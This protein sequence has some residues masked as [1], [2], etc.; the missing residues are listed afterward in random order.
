MEHDIYLKFL[1][2]LIKEN[3]LDEKTKISKWYH[4]EEISSKEI[5]KKALKV[6]IAIV[7][8]ELE[9]KKILLIE[10]LPQN[11]L[12]SHTILVG[13]KTELREFQIQGRNETFLADIRIYNRLRE[14]MQLIKPKISNPRKLFELTYKFK[15][16]ELKI[17]KDLKEYL[18]KVKGLDFNRVHVTLSKTN[19]LFLPTIKQSH[20]QL[21]R[22]MHIP[23]IPLLD[24]AAFIKDSTMNIED[25]L[26]I[27]KH[28]NPLFTYEKEVLWDYDK[29]SGKKLQK[30]ITT[31]FI[32]NINRKELSQ[33]INNCRKVNFRKEEIISEL[34]NLKTIELSSIDAKVPMPIW[35]SHKDQKYI[36]I[37]RKII[38]SF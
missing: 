36:E 6:K 34:K 21:A 25:S 12:I 24:N 19:T 4:G 37:K 32:V 10:D 38:I 33:K 8:L 5:E 18:T 30:D 26:S 7:E 28:I 13:E 1:H 15:F 22:D 2:K 16:E 17:M 31:N 14:N 35:K 27:E 20:L 9:D 3:Y 23:V 11:F 29:N